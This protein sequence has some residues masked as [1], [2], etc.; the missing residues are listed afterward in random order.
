MLIDTKQLQQICDQISEEIDAVV[1]IFADRG[2]IVCS[3]RRNRIGAFHTGVAKVM[4]GEINR[5]EASADDARA[6]RADLGEME[7]R[8]A[9]VAI[10]QTPD[11]ARRMV[12][13]IDEIAG[14]FD[15]DLWPIRIDHVRARAE[16]LPLDDIAARYRELGFEL[17]ARRAD[18]GL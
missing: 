11:T 12:D 4:A 1:S 9:L 13:R 18:R 3:S 2:E 14:R 7:L 16:H 5:F 8:C 6:A 17:F 10:D 15:G